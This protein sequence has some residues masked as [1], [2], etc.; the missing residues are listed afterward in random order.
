MKLS[1]HLNIAIDMKT[2][3]KILGLAIVGTVLMLSIAIVIADMLRSY[4]REIVSSVLVSIITISM[5]SP[6]F[7]MESKKEWV[8]DIAIFCMAFFP[9]EGII[10]AGLL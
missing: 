2:F 6:L 10:I 7:V 1:I 9:I 3:M 8:T 4:D 5:V